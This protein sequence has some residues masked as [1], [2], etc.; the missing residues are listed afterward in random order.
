MKGK[1]NSL[2]VGSLIHKVLEV[3]YDHMIKGFPRNTS[4]SQGLTAG[5]LYIQGCPFCSSGDTD[6]P[7]CKHEPAEYPGLQ[8]TPELNEGWNVGWKFALETC[9]Q[10]FEMYKNDSF[11]PLAA[12]SVKGEV[13]Y[14]DDEIRVLWKAK[15]DLIIDTNQI[16]IVSVDHKT[17]KQRR[18]KSSLS[19]QFMGHCVL[20]KSRNVIVNK[21]GL[22]TTLKISERLTREVVS[23][24]KDRLDEW[25]NETIPYEAYRLIQFMESG[26]WPPDYTHC[27]NL[28]GS[29]M[30]K[31]VCESDRGMRVEVLRAEFTKSP[32]WDPHNRD[33]D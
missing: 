5:N 15:F 1:S 24:S 33:E 22:Q 12:E 28:Y 11:I 25:Q 31:P 20:L 19:N 16:G 21:I 27:D 7:E 10:Y 13:I 14:E 29:C 32:K 9:E 8:N 26:Y 18:N 2:E 6:S 4:I 17:F 23:Y 3:Y 30:F